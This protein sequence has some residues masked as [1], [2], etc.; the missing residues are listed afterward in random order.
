MS[1]DRRHPNVVHLSAVEPETESRGTRFGHT[2][3]SLTD[4]TAARGLG[5]AWYEVPPGRAAFP[6]HWHSANE[7][8][9][10]IL[11]GQGTLRI[12]DRQIDVRAGD[13]ATFL[14]GPEHTHQLVNTG[15]VPLRYL[16]MSTLSTTEVVGYPDSGKVGL[17]AG[18]DVQAMYRAPWAR[19]I[20]RA[21]KTLD[22]YDGE[23][24][25]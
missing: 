9:I 15:T 19:V 1:A 7:E 14:T 22:Y 20:A 24:V 18:A 17:R 5:C 25:D 10:F 11:E 12:G 23:K 8:A 3:R 4:F 21:D 6:A 13:W 16:G 2:S